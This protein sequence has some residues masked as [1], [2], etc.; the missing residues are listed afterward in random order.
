MDPNRNPGKVLESLMQI[1]HPKPRTL[2]SPSDC[3]NRDLPRH[4]GKLLSMDPD[5]GRC[6]DVAWMRR[7]PGQFYLKVGLGRLSGGI[8]ESAFKRVFMLW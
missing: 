6:R 7:E 8:L 2:N 4:R 3:R 5:A 1:P